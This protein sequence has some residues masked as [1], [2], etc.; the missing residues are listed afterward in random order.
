MDRF[1]ATLR[2]IALG[3]LLTLGLAAPVGAA[4]NPPEV[5][6]A[7]QKGEVVKVDCPAGI[8]QVVLERREG[9]GWKPVAT[10]HLSWGEGETARTLHFRVPEALG[11]AGLRAL[12]FRT[13]KFPARTAA[14]ARR[15]KRGAAQGSSAE[16]PLYTLSSG[17]QLRAE[18][19]D[20]DAGGETA[21]ESDIWKIVGTRLFFFNQYRGLQ[22]FDMTDPTAPRRTGTLRLAA[23]GEQ[24]YA[25]DPQAEH[26][27]L[28]GRSN[29]AERAGLPAL[30]L[31]RVVD[32]VPSLLSEV[33]LEGWTSD[34]RL[35]GTRL[36]LMSTLYEDASGNWQP[37]ALI[38]AIELAD[39][40]N[41]AVLPSLTLEG[42][43]TAMQA[44]G[45]R[46]LIATSGGSWWWS[47][48]APSQINL[49][50]IGG[51]GGAPVLRKRFAAKG[52]VQDKFKLG[53][54]DGAAAVTSLI[55]QNGRQETWVETFPLAGTETAPLAQLELEGARGEQL[56]A[57]RYDG[58]RLYVVTFRNTDPLFVID[59]SDPA[60]PALA[61]SLEIP[62]WSTYIEPLG[63]RLLTMGVESGQAVLSLFGVAD[64]AAPTLLS[65]LA[66]GDQWSWSEANYDEK[67]VEYF[68]ESGIV[69]VPFQT[70]GDGGC[71]KAVQAVA[72]GSDA[73]TAQATIRH[74]FD[75]RRGAVMGDYFVSI[76]GQE[77]LVVDRSQDSA[78]PLVELSL[79][80][81]ADRV[82]ALGDYLVQIEDGTSGDGWYGAMVRLPYG[83]TATSSM[84]RV[85]RSDDPDALVGEID[86]GAGRILGSVSRDNRLYLAQWVAAVG[87]QPALVRTWI[88]DLAQAPELPT[89][90]TLDHPLANLSEWDLDLEQAELLWVGAHTLALHAP[91][92][93]RWGW[94]GYWRGPIALAGD[95]M[96]STAT[97]VKMAPAPLGEDS[98][99]AIAAP[100]NL[101]GILCPIADA[102]TD[103]TA[104]PA[105]RI[106]TAGDLRGSSRAFAERGFVFFSFDTATQEPAETG[107]ADEV[108]T[109]DGT[110]VTLM[111]IWMP[112][113]ETLHSWLQVVDLRFAEPVVRDPVSI[114]G[115][116]LSVAQ[117]DA[118]GAIVITEKERI[119]R[120][121]SEAAR[122]LQALAYDGASAYLL[123]TFVTSTPFGA[124]SA[125][126]GTRMFLAEGSDNPGVVAVGYDGASGRLMQTGKWDTAVPDSLYSVGSYLLGART[127]V[128]SVAR[129]GSLG[130][131]SQVADY[132]TPANLWLRLDR[133]AIVPGTGLWIPAGDYGV[134]SLPWAELA[135]KAKAA[136]N[137]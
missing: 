22:V 84:L 17:T 87:E 42:Y 14:G 81:A 70:C 130:E 50:G 38:Q 132:S 105:V 91:V 10:R 109:A 133:T 34:S 117:A 74:D 60:A 29:S 111:P 21:V 90:A 52:W 134:E 86:L 11:A 4:P 54:V 43:G 72:V 46:L 97:M 9:R 88:L 2:L 116:L 26:L 107:L 32:G 16:A 51:A 79:A 94:W 127:G 3:L 24:L 106:E 85:T 28:I 89:L 128:L 96:A 6:V 118:Q 18:E 12:A 119:D 35:I 125:T 65:R 59:L 25:L 110:L 40:A 108:T 137:R 61:G 67:A 31:L 63:D 123:D 122:S 115:Q 55:W 76:S 99:L 36:Y 41:P 8:A 92:Q 48:S 53:V 57:T 98:N 100:A 20:P 23:S 69:L 80:W 129:I 64:P 78:E 113:T 58:D 103:P 101:A 1:A 30:Y 131:L 49:V 37:Q 104:I 93:R 77:L 45:N 15:F 71:T 126:D 33:P 44:A 135:A 19:G 39:P 124:A 136:A 114:P 112:P 120:R 121:S 7:A 56:H 62:G 27:A 47:S 102:D 73:L 95:V 13:A 68:A 5:L 83:G 66:L 82:V 75:P